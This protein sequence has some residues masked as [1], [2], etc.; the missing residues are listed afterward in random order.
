MSLGLQGLQQKS[1]AQVRFH[2]PPSHSSFFDIARDLAI[3]Y[4]V[5]I[6]LSLTAI[7]NKFSLFAI[8]L[9]NLG[10]GHLVM[11]AECEGIEQAFITT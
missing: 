11:L 2:V 8:S 5:S 10:I 7:T 9:Q 3:I 1:P 4:P 6:H